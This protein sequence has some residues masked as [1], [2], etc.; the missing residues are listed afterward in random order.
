MS[1]TAKVTGTFLERE[2][3][4]LADGWMASSA[5]IADFAADHY[6]IPREQIDV[7]HCGV[8]CEMFRPPGIGE[9]ID[10]RPTVLFVGNI[11]ASKGPKTVFEALLRI[12]DQFPNF[13]Y[14]VLGRGEAVWEE[15][16]S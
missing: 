2:S 8:D 15:L 6:E 11:A 10:D 5:N 4:R 14:Q 13:R 16:G 9:R 3:I 1:R 12:K 7:V